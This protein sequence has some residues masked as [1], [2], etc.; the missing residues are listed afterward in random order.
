MPDILVLIP[1]WESDF[2]LSKSLLSSVKT[3]R[4]IA[5]GELWK[6]PSELYFGNYVEVLN[7]PSV[8][9]Y[10]IN[11]LLVTVPATFASIVLGSLAGYVFAK[12]PF[13]GSEILFLILVSG[14][15]FPPQVILIPLFR[16]FNSLGL[17]DTL[18]P[19]FLVHTALGI[20][21]C[22]LLMRNFF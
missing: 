14:M 11:T 9:Q 18:W 4:D 20:P 19:I 6:I 5:L 21:I 10:F 2:N 1:W 3:T 15:F 22:S 12:L 8:G 7:N 13:R 17:I 16:L